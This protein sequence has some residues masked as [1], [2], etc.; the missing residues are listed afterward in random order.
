[1]VRGNK[2]RRGRLGKQALYRTGGRLLSL[3]LCRFIWANLEVPSRVLRHFARTQVQSAVLEVHRPTTDGKRKRTR[4]IRGWLPVGSRLR[5]PLPHTPRSPSANFVC[6][7]LVPDANP[8]AQGNA[9]RAGT[10]SVT[11]P[12]ARASPLAPEKP[13][14]DR[15]QLFAA[16]SGTSGEVPGRPRPPGGARGLGRRAPQVAGRGE[17]ASR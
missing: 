3:I 7:S 1:M 2:T 4:T 10:R 9:P 16:A 17:L 11:L 13:A 15:V 6:L 12:V 5:H 14:A 8:T